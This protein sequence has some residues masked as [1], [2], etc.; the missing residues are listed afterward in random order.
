MKQTYIESSSNPRLKF[1]KKLDKASVRKETGLFVI[2]GM[3]ETYLAWKSGI[4]FREV[5]LKKSGYRK[6]EQYDVMRMLIDFPGEIV[7]LSDQA[8]AAVT[9]REGTEG[10]IVVAETRNVSL[11]AVQ[12][13]E[14]GLALVIYGVEKPGNIGAMLRT[15]DAAGVDLVMICEAGTDL[16]NPNL[17]RASLGTVF[18][19][20]CVGCSGPELFSFAKKHQIALVAADPEGNQRYDQWNFKQATAIVVGAEDL[21]LPASALNQTDAKLSIPMKGTI[22]SLNVSV[23]AAILLYEACRQR[24]SGQSV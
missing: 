24:S 10:I 5:Y 4:V 23:S 16:Y 22:D 18:T 9:Y 21:G 11:N 19:N 1:I 13:P 12:F 3:R 2:E 8:Y 6:D 15:A 20:T 7:F 17:I 14:G